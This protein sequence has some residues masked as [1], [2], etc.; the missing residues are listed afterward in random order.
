VKIVTAQ[1]TRR[2]RNRYPNRPQNLQNQRGINVLYRQAT[3][4]RLAVRLD[5]ACPLRGML[6]IFRACLVGID[7]LRRVYSKRDPT[8]GFDSPR[9]AFRLARPKWIK[10]ARHDA[11]LFGCP[12]TRIGEADGI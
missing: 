6:L 11:A 2:F 3:D 4:N 10:S 5:R 9:P 7:V 8:S 1:A 12:R